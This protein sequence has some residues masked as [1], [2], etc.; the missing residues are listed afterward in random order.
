MKNTCHFEV[1]SSRNNSEVARK[2]KTRATLMFNQAEIRVKWH[3]NQKHV[4]L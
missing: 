3:V 2:S 1:Q 4:P